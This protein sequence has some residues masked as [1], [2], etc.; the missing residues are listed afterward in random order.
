MRRW[1]VGDGDELNFL[2][3]RILIEGLRE[4]ESLTVHHVNACSSGT[5][6]LVFISN[7]IFDYFQASLVAIKFTCDRV[8][9]KAKWKDLKSTSFDHTSLTTAGFSSKVGTVVHFLF[10]WHVRCCRC[11][12][13][14]TFNVNLIYSTWNLWNIKPK[15][16]KWFKYKQSHENENRIFFYGKGVQI[17][18]FIHML[19][20]LC[21]VRLKKPQRFD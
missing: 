1:L 14:Y 11:T 18:V 6:S 5:A 20:W 21:C 7:T 19:M 12:A 16:W 4:E 8:V 2:F 17:Y 15:L 13:K 9:G 3:C 10:P